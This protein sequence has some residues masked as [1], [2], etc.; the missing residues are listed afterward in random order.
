VLIGALV[1]APARGAGMACIARVTFWMV[2]GGLLVEDW[3]LDFAWFRV[4]L[5]LVAGEGGLDGGVCS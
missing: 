3:R 1:R 2:H 5:G 4:S